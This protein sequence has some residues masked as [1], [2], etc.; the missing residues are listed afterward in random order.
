MPLTSSSVK[1][2]GGEEWGGGLSAVMMLRQPTL[3]ARCCRSCFVLHWQPVIDAGASRFS[4]LSMRKYDW[5]LAVRVYVYPLFLTH[6]SGEPSLPCLH[7]RPLCASGVMVDV[8]VS[9]CREVDSWMQHGR[10]GCAA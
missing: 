4:V 8:V 6:G 9:D 5:K 10:P 7:V 1:V 3:I 2:G